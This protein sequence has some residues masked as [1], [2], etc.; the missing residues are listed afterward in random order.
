MYLIYL[1]TYTKKFFFILSTI[2]VAVGTSFDVI[3]I[4][5][6]GQGI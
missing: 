6:P 4:G 5:G 3:I 2:I 1:L